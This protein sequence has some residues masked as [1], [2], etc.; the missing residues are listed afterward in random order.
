MDNKVPGKEDSLEL[1]RELLIGISNITPEEVPSLNCT[2]EGFLDTNGVAVSDGDWAE[3]FRSELISIS[4]E[5]SP[6]GKVL[7]VDQAT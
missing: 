7:P 1:A 5:Q 2:P 4:Y 3:K 6:D